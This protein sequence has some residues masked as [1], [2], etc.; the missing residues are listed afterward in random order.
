ML[1]AQAL[2]STRSLTLTCRNS[3]CWQS[4]EHCNN[5]LSSLWPPLLT[6]SIDVDRAWSSRGMCVNWNELQYLACATTSELQLVAMAVTRSAVAPRKEER[7]IM[8]SVT[9]F[10]T[11]TYSLRGELLGSV[12]LSACLVCIAF[13]VFSCC[14]SVQ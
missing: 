7:E 6:R 5:F 12:I 1:S 4:C 10:S 3:P 9:C 13:W 8:K 11:P 2:S 14:A